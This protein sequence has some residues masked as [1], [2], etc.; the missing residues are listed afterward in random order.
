[1]FLSS[2]L[3]LRY[4]PYNHKKTRLLAGFFIGLLNPFSIG[5]I[6]V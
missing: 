5:S 2:L 4:Y 6:L 1:M 3:T